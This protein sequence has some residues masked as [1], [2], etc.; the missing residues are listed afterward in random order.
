MIIQGVTWI[1]IFIICV[2]MVSIPV[3]SNIIITA[4]AQGFINPEA[5]LGEDLGVNETSS[6][7]PSEEEFGTETL[8]CSSITPREEEFG[9]ETLTCSSITPREEEFGTETSGSEITPREEEFG[10]E[11]EASEI[12]PNHEFA[13]LN[14]SGSEYT[15][16][17]LLVNTNK[18][19]YVSDE[20]VV[21][22][23]GIIHSGSSGPSK[24][25]LEVKDLSTNSTI[26]KSSK[27]T[28]GYFRFNTHPGPV[29]TYNA[30]VSLLLDKNIE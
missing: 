17:S 2:L 10:D 19:V 22:F 23:G 18:D 24:I 11:I 25:L 6:I 16:V 20:V 15:D 21:I 4:F 1:L 3:F 26:Y 12:T 5:D 30:T 13:R 29:G 8:T 7:T 14:A 28:N 27:I 9:T